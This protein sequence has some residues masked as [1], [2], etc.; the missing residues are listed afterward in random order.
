MGKKVNNKIQNRPLNTAKKVDA[1]KHAQDIIEIIR[2]PFL[3]LDSSLHVVTA[4]PAFY[5]AFKVLK[6]NT[7]GVL[8]YE[9]GNQQW[10]IPLL[11]E[12]LE[13]ILPKKK[14]TKGFKVVH[15]FPSIGEKIMLLHARQIDN[16]QLIL[17]VIEDVTEAHTALASGV[18]SEKLFRALIEKSTDAV[19]LVDP[20]GKVLYCSPSTQSVTGFT[21]EE[22]KKLTNPFELVPPDDRKFVTRLFEELLKKPGGSTHAIYRIKHKN[23]NLIWIESTMTNLIMDSNV[24]AVVLNYRDVTERKDHERQKEEFIGIASHELKTPVTSIKGYGQVLQRWMGKEGNTKA[25]EFLQKMDAQ[26]NKLTSLIGDLLDSTKLEGGR[27]QFHA[28]QYDFNELVLNIVDEMQQTTTK[29]LLVTRIAP[30]KTIYGDR[31][32]IG[33]VITN[34]ISNALKYSPH[35]KEIIIT[36][37]ANKES[38]TLSVKDFGNG[39]A[40]NKQVKVFDRFFRVSGKNQDTFAGLGL[41]LYIA[42]EIVKRHN[43]RTWVESEVNEGTTFSFSVPIKKSGIINQQKNI[44]VEEE[45]KHE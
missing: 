14:E 29:H 28:E 42:A 39:I 34:F 21:R 31:D 41:G 8:V 33:Q 43:G 24:A 16:V 2:E 40:K 13:D 9:L 17:L 32:R 18:K 19:A 6:K 10:N 45:I 36:T 30:T 35:S 3:V 5:K 44:L 23:N 25:V 7:E 20:K 38:V 12:L 22:F 26:L 1:V 27:L 4:N 11:R 15:N 37:T